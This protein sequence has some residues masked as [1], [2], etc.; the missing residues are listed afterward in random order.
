MSIALSWREMANDM[1]E[2]PPR[3]TLHANDWYVRV[4]R[5]QRVQ[6]VGSPDGRRQL[7]LV[8]LLLCRIVEGVQYSSIN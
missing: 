4:R 1:R 8:R 6:A 7:P 3:D 5:R 2:R